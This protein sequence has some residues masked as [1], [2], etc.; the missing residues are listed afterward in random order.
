MAPQE[1]AQPIPLIK[2]ESPRYKPDP[3]DLQALRER[4]GIEDEQELMDLVL[5]VQKE[6]YAVRA[7][8][9]LL[10]TDRN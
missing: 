3:K 9:T 7:S 2:L 6:A 10:T 4:T 1:P 8:S 5:E